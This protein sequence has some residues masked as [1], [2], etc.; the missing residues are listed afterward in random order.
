MT[1]PSLTACIVPLATAA[2][3]HF[4]DPGTTAWIEPADDAFAAVVI[5]NELAWRRIGVCDLTIYGVTVEL[6]YHPGRNREPDLFRLRVPA[7]FE[8][9]P[10]ELIVPDETGATMLVRMT[11]PQS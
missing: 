2:L 11:G 10:P 3:C 5:R 6:E 8:A 9:D 4:G 7:G 1:C